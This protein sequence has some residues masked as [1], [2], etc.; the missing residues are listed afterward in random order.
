MNELRRLAYLQALGIDSLVSRRDLPGAL[1][2]QRVGIKRIETAPTAAPANAPM[3]LVE[4]LRDSSKTAEAVAPV[5]ATEP[6]RS[7]VSADPGPVFSVLS[8]RAGGWLWID[9]VPRGRQ[10]DRSYGMLLNAVCQAFGM[11]TDDIHVERF[12][13]PIADTRQLG[14][15][16]QAARDGFTGFLRGRLERA[17]VSGIVLL[18]VSDASWFDRDALSTTCITSTVSAWQMLRQPQLKRQAWIELRESL[19]S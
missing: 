4:S 1:P 12:D 7:A 15:S 11:P 17:P 5:P 18:G 13:W 14:N 16:Q 9:E 6:V 10:H 8:T 19:Q 2:S 3:Q